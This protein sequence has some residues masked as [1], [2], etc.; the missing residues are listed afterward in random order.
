V[1]KEGGFS[2][3]LLEPLRVRPE[4]GSRPGKIGKIRQNQHIAR[5]T[6]LWTFILQ[7]GSM[8]CVSNGPSGLPEPEVEG[9]FLDFSPIESLPG[10]AS[11]PIQPS[12]PAIEKVI[13]RYPTC[14]ALL[15]PDDEKWSSPVWGGRFQIFSSPNAGDH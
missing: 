12:S 3:F 7:L 4:R 5:S 2:S 8:C 15:P 13:R 1:D 14:A 10:A 6:L 11:V 9:Y